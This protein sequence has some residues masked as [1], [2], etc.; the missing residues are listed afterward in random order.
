MEEYLGKMS[1]RKKQL[2]D[3]LSRSYPSSLKPYEASVKSFMFTDMCKNYFDA[4]KKGTKKFKFFSLIHATPFI[5]RKKFK[6]HPSEN[7]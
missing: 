2:L 1:D 3:Y 5:C 7:L 6:N 4:V